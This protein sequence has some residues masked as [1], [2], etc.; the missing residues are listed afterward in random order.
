MLPKK[1]R[2][3]F[4]EFCDAAYDKE[5]LADRETA[6]L[7]LAVAMAVGCY[8]WMRHYLGVARELGLT[9]D[10]IGAVESVVMAVSA[11][12]IRTQFADARKGGSAKST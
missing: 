10:E 1:Q 11:C 9:E 5:I 3:A 7:Q 12:R 6:M 8:P 2:D 4:T